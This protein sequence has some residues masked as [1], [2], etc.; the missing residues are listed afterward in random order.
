MVLQLISVGM[1]PL[2]LHFSVGPLLSEI[3]LM[4]KFTARH[5]QFSET[6]CSEGIFN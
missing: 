3:K 6:T 5:I 1:M 4:S 2:N